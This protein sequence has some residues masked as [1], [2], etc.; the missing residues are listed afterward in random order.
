MVVIFK[1]VNNA[2]LEHV[3]KKNFDNKHFLDD[4][5]KDSDVI[6]KVIYD[7]VVLN[8]MDYKI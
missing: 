2:V 8:G 7:F 4:G 1:V 3:V 6:V 5:M